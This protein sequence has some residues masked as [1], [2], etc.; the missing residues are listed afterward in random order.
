MIIFTHVVLVWVHRYQMQLEVATRNGYYGLIIFHS[1]LLMIIISTIVKQNISLLLMRISFIIV[2]AGA[3]GA[4]FKYDV[5][6]IY[7]IPV[8]LLTILGLLGLISKYFQNK[9]Q[10]FTA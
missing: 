8:I 5:V 7:K 2:A 10:K 1:A 3:I 6:S 9:R 4:S